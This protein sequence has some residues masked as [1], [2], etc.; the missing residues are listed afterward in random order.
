MHSDDFSKFCVD[1]ERLGRLYSGCYCAIEG[2]GTV[3]ADRTHSAG[4]LGDGAVA[5]ALSAAEEQGWLGPIGSRFRALRERDDFHFVCSHEPAHNCGKQL[6][7]ATA[8]HH[9][10]K[11]RSL[12]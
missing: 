6:N 11:R 1:L 7:H 8:I 10:R 12:G 5:V 4:R 2:S 9:T 3:R